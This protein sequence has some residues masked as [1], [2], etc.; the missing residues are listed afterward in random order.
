MSGKL[1][2]FSGPSG[3]GKGSICNELINRGGYAFSVS[4]TTRAPRPGE[5]DGVS[6]YF[7][8][9]DVFDFCLNKKRPLFNL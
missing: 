9:Q 5:I 2:V 7:V 8:S 1:I 3:V 6:Y 4:M